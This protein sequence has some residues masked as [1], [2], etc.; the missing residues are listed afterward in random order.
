MCWGFLYRL[1]ALDDALLLSKNLASLANTEE[2]KFAAFH[3]T[4]L[5]LLDLGRPNVACAAFERS[6]EIANALDRKDFLAQALMSKGLIGLLTSQEKETDELLNQSLSICEENGFDELFALNQGYLGQLYFY[7]LSDMPKAEEAHNS[8]LAICEKHNDLKGQA[9]QL[10]NL[11][12]ISSRNG[13][14]EQAEKFHRRALEIDERIG[15]KKGIASHSANIAIILHRAGKT[16]EAAPYGNRHDEIM[17]E[18]GDY[19]LAYHVYHNKDDIP[20]F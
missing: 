6:A 19:R 9:L 8:A 7:Q 2:Q 5:T 14:D 12:L 4:G 16:K 18:I 15:W 3:A 17:S 11:G 13:D 20:L 10:C 1:C